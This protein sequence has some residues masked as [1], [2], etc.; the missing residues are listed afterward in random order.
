MFERFKQWFKNPI[1][2]FCTVFF[3]GVLLIG[4][5]VWLFFPWTVGPTAKDRFAEQ[6][7]QVRVRNVQLTEELKALVRT[8]VAANEREKLTRQ[9][10]FIARESLDLYREELKLSATRL[11]KLEKEARDEIRNEEDLKEVVGQIEKARNAITGYEKAVS[12]LSGVLE[13]SLDKTSTPL[14]RALEK[15][16][17]DVQK[18]LDDLNAPPEKPK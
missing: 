16:F 1:V 14:E 6:V 5:G 10:R 7:T 4:V 18:A 2:A 13:E 12:I 17:K 9:E 11:E 3:S 8:A 15:A